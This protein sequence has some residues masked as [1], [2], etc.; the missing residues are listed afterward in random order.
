M[1]SCPKIVAAD[2]MEAVGYAELYAKG[3]P[4]VIGGALDQSQQFVESARFIWNE[5]AYW[6]AKQLR[7]TDD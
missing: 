2:A 1:T 5:Q 4:P 3:L 6:K 7:V